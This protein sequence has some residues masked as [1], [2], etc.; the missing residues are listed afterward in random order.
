MLI[1][2]CD[3]FY[4]LETGYYSDYAVS[5]LTDYDYYGGRVQGSKS[6]GICKAI[7]EEFSFLC[8]NIN[9]LGSLQ[10][11]AKWSLDLGKLP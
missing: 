9:V 11:K 1:G 4:H 10:S 6:I 3:S 8:I 5:S 7:M 2:L